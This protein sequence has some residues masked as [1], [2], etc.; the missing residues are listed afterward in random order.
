MS[1]HILLRFFVGHGVNLVDQP[2]IFAVVCP[3]TI[4]H[5]GWQRGGGE[6]F[7]HHAD[8]LKLSCI[9]KNKILTTLTS[10]LLSFDL[11]K[12]QVEEQEKRA[13]SWC[14]NYILIFNVSASGFKLMILT[15]MEI[16]K[17]NHMSRVLKI[18]N[19]AS[20]CYAQS[21]LMWLI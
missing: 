4:S 8:C 10:I 11:K 19:H 12:S 9:S 20:R 15:I 6:P 2:T 14:H 5:L 1:D 18:V 3:K 21:H 7:M 13:R 17:E 16:S